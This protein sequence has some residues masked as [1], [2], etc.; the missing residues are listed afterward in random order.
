MG[1]EFHE[2]DV[3]DFANTI[4]GEKS[5]KGEELFFRYCPYCQGGNNHDKNT[6]SINLKTGVFHCFRS[7]CGKSGHF[8]ELARDFHYALDFGEIKQYRTFPQK[9]IETRQKA[10]EY[11]T[12]RGID[13]D[14]VERYHIT[15]R[16]DNQ[17][18][19]VFPFYDADGILR[20]VKYR[21]T[22][23]GKG[24]KEWGEKDAMP[25]LFGMDHC[26]KDGELIITEGQIDA[27]SVACC[28]DY[29][30]VS[31]P[32]GAKGFTWFQHCAEWLKRFDTV[33][34]FGDC[35]KGKV[36]LLA[37]LQKLL[38]QKMKVVQL[39]DYLGEK[40][41][42][43]I[44]RKYG[45]NAIIY[46]IAHAKAPKMQNIKDLSE[47]ESVDLE[48]MEHI[49]SGN[50]LLDRI[51]GGFYLGQLVLLSGKRGSGKSTLASQFA[52]EA[53]E[54][55]HGIFVYSG[56]L[57]DYHFKRW[58]DLQ[59]AGPEYLLES[60]NEFLQKSYRIKPDA[61]EKINQWY[62]GRAFIYDNAYMP[63]AEEETESLMDTMEQAVRLYD[64][65]FILIDNLM[66]A[67]DD[68]V[69]DDIYR[70][71]SKFVGELKR[72]AMQH[73][74]V[75]L[76]VAHPRKNS[77]AGKAGNDD[78]SG[79][80]DITNKVDTVLFFNRPPDTE[81]V[82]LIEVTKNRL[83]GRLA[84]GKYAIQT[85]YSISSKR[86]FSPVDGANKSYGWEHKE[87]PPAGFGWTQEECPF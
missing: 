57:P 34:V 33:I 59:L 52:A 2:Q 55:G 65:R 40:D 85:V 78:V 73:Q 24:P 86:I 28:G 36:T 56:E 31:V 72:F 66:T 25:I 4:P 18:I 64:L 20:M 14:V 22:K 60:E 76:L 35:E 21:N 13:A 5:Q 75:V 74:V 6:F 82:G 3:F 47:V 87:A 80:G 81:N 37:E 42:N 84:V 58:L 38:A 77:E 27:L 45:K 30:V 16:K 79:S 12:G 1:Y 49:H 8:V 7:G 9:K 15:T 69:S 17:N 71:Q 83:T 67:M 46:A 41:A 10:V 26:K 54:Q 23:P 61:Q 43:D 32:N 29:S 62:R 11:L 39:S 68:T 51:I 48:G 50:T 63:S 53:L 19:L 70:A 44:L